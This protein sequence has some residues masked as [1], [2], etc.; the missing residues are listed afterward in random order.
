MCHNC[1]VMKTMKRNI[2]FYAA[3]NA[4]VAAL[5]AVLTLPFSVISF[6][7]MQLRLSEALTVLPCLYPFCAPGLF[8]GCALS[9]L[10]SPYG[11]A[12]ILLGSLLTLIAAFLSSRLKNP[13]LGAIP[14]VL[15]NAFGLPLM[16]LFFAGEEAYWANFVSI[17]ISQSI[18]IYALGV[19]LYYLLKRTLGAD[20]GIRD[21]GQTPVK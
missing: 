20:F 19:P 21:D 14:P 12:D 9:N 18:V 4:V 8:I 17:L 1:T 11:L 2:A 3:F 6:G 5:Y 13:F 10:A 7:T 16:W 15:V